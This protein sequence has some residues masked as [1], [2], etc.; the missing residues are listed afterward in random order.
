MHVKLPQSIQSPYI[1]LSKIAIVHAKL[2]CKLNVGPI[3]LNFFCKFDVVKLNVLL[4]AELFL[5]FKTVHLEMCIGQRAFEGLK[6]FFV[7]PTQECNTYCY[8]YQVEMDELQIGLKNMQQ[9]FEVCITLRKIML[10]LPNFIRGSP[11][12]G[13]PLFVLKGN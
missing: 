8:I 12:F 11:I 3:S 2:V 7:K 10:L 6:P 13:R 4:K 9:K 5:R 1:N